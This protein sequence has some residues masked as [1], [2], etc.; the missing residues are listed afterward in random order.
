[1]PHSLV[2]PF[3]L[4]LPL[5]FLKQLKLPPPLASLIECLQFPLLLPTYPIDTSLLSSSWTI[6]FPHTASLYILMTP[7]RV[8]G[9]SL[10]TQPNSNQITVF[11]T[12]LPGSI[13]CYLLQWALEHN[14]IKLPHN[15]SPIFM[16]F[17][18]PGM[19]YFSLLLLIFHKV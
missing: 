13:P 3:T 11:P 2:P 8:S 16:L 7:G 15:I 4:L 5:H 10:P 17:P 19:L 6:S 14:H 12:H 1:M 9:L 18:L